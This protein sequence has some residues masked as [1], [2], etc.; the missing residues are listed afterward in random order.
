[1]NTGAHFA[2]GFQDGSIQVLELLKL[3]YNDCN[4]K[5]SMELIEYMN[6]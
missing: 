3:L 1:M 2:H 5:V 4:F 6:A